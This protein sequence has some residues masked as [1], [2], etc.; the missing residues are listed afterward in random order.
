MGRKPLTQEEKRANGAYKK[1]PQRENKAAPKALYGRPEKPLDVMSCEVASAKWDHIVD[2]LSRMNVM[3][4]TDHDLM[5]R[6][7][8]TWAQY[9][10]VHSRLKIV[11]HVKETEKGSQRSPESTSWLALNDAL[12]KMTAELGLSPSSRGKLHANPEAGDNDPF[13][14]WLKKRTGASTN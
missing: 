8:L 14:E 7:C 2:M 4:E 10:E 12:H 5:A 1:D 3:A 13:A 6:Y 11:G 9:L